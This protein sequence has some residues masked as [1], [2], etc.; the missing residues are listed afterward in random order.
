MIYY[1]HS[2]KDASVTDVSNRLGCSPQERYWY[3]FSMQGAFFFAPSPFSLISIIQRVKKFVN[4]K[5]KKISK[6]TENIVTISQNKCL[7]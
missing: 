7:Y 4:S 1:L 2:T 5:L 6:L 3:Y